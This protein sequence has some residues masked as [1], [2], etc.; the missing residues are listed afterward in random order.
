MIPLVLHLGRPGKDVQHL[1]RHGRRVRNEPCQ[2]FLTRQCVLVLLGQVLIRKGLEPRLLVLQELQG[3][4][5]VHL[6][7]V[8]QVLEARL[9]EELELLHVDVGPDGLHERGVLRLVLQVEVRAAPLQDVRGLPGGGDVRFEAGASGAQVHGRL[10]V[11]VRRVHVRAQLDEELHGSDVPQENRVVDGAVVVGVVVLGLLVEEQPL[12]LLAPRH[13][14]VRVLAASSLV[15]VMILDVLEES[16]DDVHVA[17]PGRQVDNFQLGHEGHLFSSSG[18]LEG[19]APP[20]DR[21]IQRI[22]QELA[23]VRGAVLRVERRDVYRLALPVLLFVLECVLLLKVHVSSSF[24]LL[25]VSSE[26]VED[27]RVHVL[28]LLGDLS[29]HA[30]RHRFPPLHLPLP[31]RL[32][33]G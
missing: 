1:A 21:R 22:P 6:D 28:R 23:Q 24:S 26:L 4:G 2:L 5:G 32:S 19:V 33:S 13:L 14:E 12:D 17:G 10:T 31:P 29:L 25:Y 18:R 20:A 30:R 7:R 9:R 27:V 3:A 8:L 11:H 16:V 15:Y